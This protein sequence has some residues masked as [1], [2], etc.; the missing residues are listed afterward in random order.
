MFSVLKT[1]GN[2]TS[3]KVTVA[4]DYFDEGLFQGRRFGT[5]PKT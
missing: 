3:A 5:P 2:V 4:V 1:F